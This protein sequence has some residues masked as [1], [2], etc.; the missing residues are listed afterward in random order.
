MRVLFVCTGNTC[1]SPMAEGLL[2]DIAKKN[3]L[4]IEVASAGVFAMDGDKAANNAVEALRKI[5]IDIS[6]HRSQNVTRELVDQA[7]LILTM[8][9]SH[10]ETLLLNYPDLKG[11][12]YLLN[13]YALNE[14]RDIQ[15]PFGRDL[16]N[17][18]M[19]RN[20]ILKALISIKW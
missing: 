1:R 11:R 18:E 20:E 19:T 17:Y 8:S 2:K 4:D 5:D 7:D 13:E 6:K 10:K 9:L 16:Y 12:I 14:N 15:D 3:K